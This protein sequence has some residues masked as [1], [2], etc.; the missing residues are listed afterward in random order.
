MPQILTPSTAPACPRPL[1][2]E[3]QSVGLRAKLD[4]SQAAAQGR[5]RLLTTMALVLWGCI[6]RNPHIGRSKTMNTYPHSVP[7]QESGDS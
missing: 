7:G 1:A 2:D 6:T 3:G 4:L 5:A